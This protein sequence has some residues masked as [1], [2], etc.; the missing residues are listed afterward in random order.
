MST[1][2]L[3]DFDRVG[4]LGSLWTTYA[5]AWTCDGDRA[6]ES[7]LPGVTNLASM[8]V[9]LGA[10]DLYPRRV[11]VKIRRPKLNAGNVECGL[12]VAP[13]FNNVGITIL[14]VKEVGWRSNSGGQIYVRTRSLLPAVA[15][16]TDQLTAAYA[17]PEDEVRTLRA[18]VFPGGAALVN[19]YVD[20]VL[21]GS[22]PISTAVG[23]NLAGIYS[24][25]SSVAAPSAAADAP[26]LDLFKVENYAAGVSAETAPGAVDDPTMT[27]LSIDSEG[28]IAAAVAL[29]IRA[30]DKSWEE[31]HRWATER[32]RMEG[33]YVV[34]FPLASQKRVSRA[35]SWSGLTDAELATLRTYFDSTPGPAGIGTWTT[36]EGEVLYFAL[37]DAAWDVAPSGPVTRRVTVRVLQ[38]RAT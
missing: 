23:A 37:A 29:P 15:S 4:A 32:A 36:P 33:R 3:D 24:F 5:G 28:L 17:W 1:L 10:S 31:D 35:F 21:I 6:K 11:S 13:F 26:L 16:F 14:N 12:L 22:A 18:D 25:R 30:P 7:G 8:A 20:D 38:V 9:A 27:T 34:R 19:V 2:A